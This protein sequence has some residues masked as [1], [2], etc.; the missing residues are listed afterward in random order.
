[1]ANGNIKKV[2]DCKVQP[3]EP[4]EMINE[5][6]EKQ[7]DEDVLTSDDVGDKTSGCV[8]SGDNVVTGENVA[9]KT[10]SG[11]VYMTEENKK[12]DLVGTGTNVLM[13]RLLYW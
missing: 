10:R 2:A 9:K 12:E 8:E 6:R 7:A 13:K 5:L 1:M 3:C 11:K 4:E